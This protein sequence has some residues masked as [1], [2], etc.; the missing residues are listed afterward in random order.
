M[1]GVTN[2]LIAGA[3]AAADGQDDVYHQIKVDLTDRHYQSINT[4]LTNRNER[5]EIVRYIDY[6][7][8]ELERLYQSIAALG[9]LTVR[10][11]DKIVSFGELLSSKILSAALRERGIS[12][13]QVSAADLIVTD[14]IFNAATPLMDLTKRKL[15]LVL[16]PLL[17]EGV[18]PVV[19]GFIGATERGVPTTL[20]RGGSDYTAAIIA[21]GLDADE[22]WIWSDVDG[23]LTAD[24]NIVA[25]ARTLVELSYAEAADLA[26]YG[27]DVL[28]PK[29][30]RPLIQQGI[31]L[32]ILNSMNP[33]HPGTFIV[34]K[35]DPNRE[36]L[37][38][39]ITTTGLTMIG[40]GSPDESWN[41]R[42]S[43]ESLE[44]LSKTGV[45]VLMFSQSF[46]EH[47]LKLVVR[48][49]DKAH[50]LKILGQ[51]LAAGCRL[52]TN[53]KVA[54][55]SVVGVPDWNQNGIVSHA[56]EALGKCGTRVIAV[57]QA[58]T[59][60]SISF[61][62]PQDKVAE[63]VTFLHRELGLD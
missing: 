28:H 17:D 56:F 33:S 4:L 60:Y 3:R 30:I 34:S 20:G 29:T 46:S 2:Q 59:E 40:I 62:I 7:L 35:T 8:D 55:V 11:T 39:I 10:V 44:R 36:H 50:C 31:P 13:I 37:P 32:R 41:L 21:A 57:A 18:A 14:D 6:S 38:S 61:C 45:D 48:E 9:E 52:G 63:T 42:M 19:P 15:D 58:A 27:A 16:R 54:T 51:D 53:E 22:V 43:A 24:P 49:Q 5:E 26:Y 1:S 23:I 25:H 12:S 47:N